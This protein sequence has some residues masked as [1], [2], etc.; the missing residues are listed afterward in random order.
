M[1]LVHDLLDQR[2]HD[3]RR[4]PLG[5][6][7]G[8]RLELRDGEPPRVTDVVV[9]GTVLMTRLGRRFGRLAAWIHRRVRGGEPT[10]T[11]I[12]VAS[13]TLDGEC[14]QA[15]DLDARDTPALAWELWL[16][17]NVVARMPFRGQ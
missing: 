6:I 8:V 5:R 14:W 13:L 3:T 9:G 16:R 1:H 17:T 11:R 7:D 4:A 2:L 15:A 12:P 10:P